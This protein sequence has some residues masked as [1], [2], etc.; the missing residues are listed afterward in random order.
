MHSIRFKITS[1]TVAV[2]LAILLTIFCLCYSSVKAESD[3]QSVEMMQLIGQDTQNTLDEYFVSIEQSV[4]MAAN[5]AIDSLDSVVLVECGAVGS[6]AG[7]AKRTPE[8]TARL[9]A[10]LAEHPEAAIKI[11]LSVAGEPVAIP[12]QKGEGTATLKAEIDRI[13]EEARQ[14]GKLAELSMKYFGRDL[15][16]EGK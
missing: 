5:E 7:R 3:R 2:I 14:N 12:M 13:L 8:Q 9:D 16:V 6:Q 10:Y 4:G 11:V 1:I 15:T